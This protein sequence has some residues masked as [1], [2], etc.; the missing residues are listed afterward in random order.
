VLVGTVVSG[1]IYNNMT[2]ICEETLPRC[3]AS[4]TISLHG[5]TEPLMPVLHSWSSKLQR[6]WIRSFIGPPT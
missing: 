1:T 5:V 6:W 2:V 4:I 3:S